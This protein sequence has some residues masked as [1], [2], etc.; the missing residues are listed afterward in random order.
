MKLLLPKNIAVGAQDEPGEGRSMHIGAAKPVHVTQLRCPQP[1]NGGSNHG[2]RIIRL[3]TA[4]KMH[5]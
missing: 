4:R 2:L 1:W 5:K 3:V